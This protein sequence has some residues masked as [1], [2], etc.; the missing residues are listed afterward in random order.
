MSLSVE[1]ATKRAKKAAATKRMKE[2]SI[3]DAEDALA[4]KDRSLARAR[5]ELKA[6]K[7]LINAGWAPK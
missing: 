4:R 3:R 5:A 1:E 7:D 6:Y 2:R